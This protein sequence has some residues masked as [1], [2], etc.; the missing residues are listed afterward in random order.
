MIIYGGL[1]KMD[2]IYTEEDTF[3]KLRQSPIHVVDKELLK[4]YDPY[5]DFN[6]IHCMYEISSLSQH[7]LDV[8]NEILHA[9][10]WTLDSYIDK[11]VITWII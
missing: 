4:L 2:N 9:H 8:I 7:D 5:V 3:K 10:Y 11:S 6:S 1:L